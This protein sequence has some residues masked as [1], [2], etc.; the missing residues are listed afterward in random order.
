LNAWTPTALPE[1]TS[2]ERQVADVLPI[3]A[4]PGEAR[5]VLDQVPYWFHTF[6]LNRDEGIYTPGYARDH[7]YRLPAIPASF[8]GRR[9][10]DV[11]T[12]DG[13]YAFLAEARGAERVVAVDNEQYVEWVRARWGVELDG[14]EGFE[15]IQRLL[16]S[17]VEYQRLDALDLDRL[18]ETFDFIF[19]FGILHRVEA[20]RRLL[21]V[22]GR[23]LAADGRVLIETHGVFA[24]PEDGEP[25]RRY[26]PGEVYAR[27][28]YVYWGFTPGGIEALG[29]ECGFARFELLDAPVVDGHPRIIG[30]LDAGRRR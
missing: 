10:L 25:V 6:A 12:F 29:R 9:V 5:A 14:G 15:A 11:G 19:C 17:A 13:F 18:D 28:E 21:E 3:D 2:A 23:R 20:P 26:G 30:R 8:A 27:D 24:D 16:G 1:L 22:L 7:R 4:E